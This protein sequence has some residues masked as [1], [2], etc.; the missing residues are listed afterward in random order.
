MIRKGSRGL[1]FLRREKNRCSTRHDRA[2]FGRTDSRPPP[3]PAP[4]GTIQGAKMF[5]QMWNCGR[6]SHESYQPDGRPPPAPSAIACADG[7][8]WTMEGP[9]VIYVLPKVVRDLNWS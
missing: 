7:M 3:P 4:F 6:V 2:R 9:K 1:F 5:C 8:A